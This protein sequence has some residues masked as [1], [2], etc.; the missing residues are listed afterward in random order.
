MIDPRRA[1]TMSGA[2]RW[3]RR[4]GPFRFTSRILSHTASSRSTIRAMAGFAPALFTR[5][6]MPPQAS[7]TRATSR[8]MSARRPM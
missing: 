3:E 1:A 8:S 2:T 7:T 5:T 4:K 6:S